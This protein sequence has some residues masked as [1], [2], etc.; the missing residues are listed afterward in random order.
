M[1]KTIFTLTAVAAAC[2]LTLFACR[3]NVK[4]DSDTSNSAVSEDVLAKIYQLGFSNKNVTADGNG[5]YIVEGDILISQEELDA[6]PEMQFLRVGDEEQY[7]TN[8]LVTGLPRN[9]TVSL[10]SALGTWSTALNTAISRY[11]A[12]GLR[13]TFTRVTSGANI[14]IVNGS[15]SFLASAGF[16][17]GGNPYNRVILNNSAVSGQP[18]NTVA[19]ILA[20]EIGHCIG[21]RHTDYMNR[22]YSCGGSPVNEG[23][24]TVG[25]VHIPG[26]PT[27]PSA[28]SWM[29]SCIGSGQNRP[30]TSSDITALNYLY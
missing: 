11:N 28:G 17:S 23:A 15:G 14:Q 27:G 5:N 21:F 20:H 26:T 7:R 2:M 19:T 24:S 4:S 29:L 8:N 30:F 18:Q 25:A 6:K 16:P 3:K 1:R 13:I 10:A 9:I 12:L 22:S